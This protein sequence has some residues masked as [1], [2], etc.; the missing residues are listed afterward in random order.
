MYRYSYKII[1]T[2]ILRLRLITFT[3]QAEAKN[4]LVIAAKIPKATELSAHK[5]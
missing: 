2:S 4:S 5:G 3:V 1:T